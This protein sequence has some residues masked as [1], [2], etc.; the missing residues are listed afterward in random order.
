MTWEYLYKID[1]SDGTECQTNLVYI[2]EYKDNVMRMTF[3]D[4]DYFND[5]LDIPDSLRGELFEKELNY[6]KKVQKFKW[7]PKLLEVKD[8]EIYIEFH[9]PTLN[10]VLLGNQG[11]LPVDYK[12]QLTNIITDLES[13]NIY[14]LTQYPHSFYLYG[15]T[16]K[17]ID[18][19]A[20]VDIDD[21]T[22]PISDIE[23]LI[24][25]NSV[26]RFV[27]AT[28]NG[29]IDFKIFY[30]Q[31]MLNHSNMYWKNNPMPEIYLST[32]TETCKTV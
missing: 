21:S 8:R 13:S 20:C 32:R 4:G 24:G 26:N 1:Y 19:Y 11:T 9:K 27:E 28:H 22:R 23:S 7:A 30:E 14:K 16:I 18:F 10:Y 3:T 2:P 5:D 29:K 6:L 17:T 12:E 15:E 31:F 25:K